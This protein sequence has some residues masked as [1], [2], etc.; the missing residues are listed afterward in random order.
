MQAE[1]GP[2][3]QPASAGEVF[4]AFNRLALQGFGGVLPVAQHVLV[5]RERW[6]D[7]ESFLETLALAQ[8]LPGGNV[9]NMALMVGDRFFG[10]RGA[11]AALAGLLALPLAI[12]LALAALHGPFAELGPVTGALRGMGAVAAGLV[13]AS[14]IKLLPALKRNVLGPPLALTLAALAFLAIALLR[15]PLLGVLGGLGLAGCLLA[16]HQGRR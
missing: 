6:L 8:V 10:L 5:E 2:L 1:A 7:E 13:I 4:L 9:V 16:W 14:A 15:W 12:V 3:R 11:L